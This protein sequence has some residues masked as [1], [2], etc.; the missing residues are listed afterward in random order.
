MPATAK[1]PTQPQRP[2]MPTPEDQ[3]RSEHQE[4]RLGI[5]HDD[6]D[7]T[8]DDFLKTVVDEDRLEAWGKGDT[9]ANAIVSQT[10]QLTTPGLY[11]TAP[12]CRHPNPAGAALVGAD[13]FLEKAGYWT[14]MQFVQFLTVGL[15]D[16]FL[17][18][19]VRNRGLTLRNVNPHNVFVVRDPNDPT[20]LLEIWE[21]RLRWWR[22]SEKWIYTWDQYS[23]G[24]EASIHANAKEPSWRIVEA[25]KDGSTGEDVSNVFLVDGDGNTGALTGN[26]YPYI[27]NGE[28]Y[29]P[30]GD[31][32]AID[33]GGQWNHF[34][35]RGL[36]RGTLTNAA[37]WTYTG[38]SALDA[39]GS[40]VLVS[41]LQ[42]VGV[43]VKTA[44][45]GKGISNVQLS[46]GA[47]VYHQPIQGAQPWAKVIGA[48]VNLPSLAEFSNL[49][50][51]KLAARSGMNPSDVV[52]Q[53][54]N[55]T[56]GAALAISNASR[57]EYSKMV[58]PIFRRSDLGAIGVQ[59]KL[60]NAAK[61]ATV[62][63]SGYSTTYHEIPLS[64]AEQRDLRE[65]LDW[66]RDAGLLSPV[67]QFQRLHPGS[68]SED[69][70]ASIVAARVDEATIEAKVRERLAEL[71][72]EEP[73]P[74]AVPNT[75]T[76]NTDEE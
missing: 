14:R 63:T 71:G 5:L 37:H 33:T 27:D 31:Y 11:G 22:Q 51:M 56:S 12:D 30:W 50:E 73:K 20:R 46:P 48:A 53:S 38:R 29:L 13:G 70:I 58:R 60:V 68:S 74:P 15:G 36:H 18:F 64:P 32:H 41:G 21:L 39:T 44:E 25:L 4:A 9:A 40:C 67:K 61:L 62:P 17:R 57:R 23:L 8:L 7:E 28:P 69:A 76:D 10:K 43:D 54:A 45:N 49:Y 1:L 6:W 55:P 16:Y 72:L 26:A 59:A 35:K 75:D 66:E 42:P 52:R 47:I 3:A 65:Q 2:K 34:E 19:D 24:Q